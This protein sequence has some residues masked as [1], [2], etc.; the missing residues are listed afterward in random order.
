[1][2]PLTVPGAALAPT[3]SRSRTRNATPTAW[4]SA[5]D[6]LLRQGHSSGQVAPR[7][8]GA[9]GGRPGGGARGLD[10]ET[11]GSGELLRP[12]EVI[13]EPDVS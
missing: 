3:R 11:P 5:E 10:R 1:M 12:V 13:G 2:I 6:V 4:T 9:T 8:A 7:G